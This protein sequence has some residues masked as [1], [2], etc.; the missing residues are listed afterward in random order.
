MKKN[1]IISII[2]IIFIL[3]VLLF[4]LL[5]DGMSAKIT[6]IFVLERSSHSII[7]NKD[8]EES[9]LFTVNISSSDYK[10][11]SN[12]VLFL[13]K[14]NKIIKPNELV[15]GDKIYILKSNLFETHLCSN[16]PVIQHVLLVKKLNY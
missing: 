5:F 8:N 16:P 10:F 12:H 2:V 7:Q 4:T 9:I 11:Y 15:N 3:L 6:D 1:I 13:N 14:Y